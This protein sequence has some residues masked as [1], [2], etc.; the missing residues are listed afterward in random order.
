MDCRRQVSQEGLMMS[1]PTI[2]LKIHICAAVAGLLSGLLAM[3]YVS[4]TATTTRKKLT[5]DE[6]TSRSSP[7]ENQLPR[8]APLTHKTLTRRIYAN[9]RTDNS[10]LF[11]HTVYRLGRPRSF[12]CRGVAGDSAHRRERAALRRNQ[13]DCA[14][15]RRS[16]AGGEL[17][18]QADRRGPQ[19]WTDRGSCRRREVHLLHQSSRRAESGPRK[20]SRQPA[21][22]PT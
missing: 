10:G 14:P 7:I 5:L 11:F 9:H 13:N 3:I 2:V 18:F 6:E 4:P 16:D 8:P 19:L 22:K 17:R 21:P 12:C 15:L 1:F 20:S